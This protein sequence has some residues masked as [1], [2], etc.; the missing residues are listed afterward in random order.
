MRHTHVQHAQQEQR[1]PGR[2][3]RQSR[4]R[5]LIAAAVGAPVVSTTV[6]AEGL[7]LVPDREILIRD[8]PDAFAA[9]VGQLLGNPEAAR[10]QAA[11]ARARGEALYDWKHIALAL[12]RELARRAGI[13]A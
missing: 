10:S 2:Q 11:A 12:A 9:A 13:R 7:D 1:G 8:G 5:A 3:R 6:G 4:A